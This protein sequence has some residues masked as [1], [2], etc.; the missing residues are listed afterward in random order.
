MM[1]K[2]EL[3]S[4]AED[5]VNAVLKKEKKLKAGE[6]FVH[7]GAD[8]FDEDIDDDGNGTF[9]IWGIIHTKNGLGANVKATGTFFP[10]V[11]KGDPINYIMVTE[12][13]DEDVEWEL[14]N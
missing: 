9:T 3:D 8:F 6:S 13:N 2:K 12:F 11:K 14:Y 10:D 4:Y 1:A 7:G 5:W